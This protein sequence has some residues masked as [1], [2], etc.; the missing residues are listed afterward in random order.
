MRLIHTNAISELLTLE[1]GDFECL[2][3]LPINR[4]QLAS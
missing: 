4:I 1:Q 2:T 3:H